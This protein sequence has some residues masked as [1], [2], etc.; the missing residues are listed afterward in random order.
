MKNSCIAYPERDALVIIRKSQVEFCDGNICA[1]ALLSFFEYWHNIKLEISV[2]NMAMNKITAMHGEEGYQDESLLQFHNMT[3]L[4]DGIMGLYGISTIKTARK[5]LV[6]KEIITEHRNPSE[7]YQFDHTI[8]YLFH[9]EIFCNWLNNRIVKNN[10]SIPPKL[11]NRK[12]ENNDS[13]VKNNDSSVKNNDSSVKNNGTITETS[14]KTS[15]K[16]TSENKDVAIAQKNSKQK[17]DEFYLAYPRKVSKEKAIKAW[18]KIKPEMYDVIIADVIN[19]NS[20]QAW[21]DK[22]F[23]IYPATYLNGKNWTDEIAPSRNNDQTDENTGYQPS[24]AMQILDPEY[25]ANFNA[26]HNAINS[27]S[28]RIQ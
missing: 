25:C 26:D 28:R 3:E 10:D 14:F 9:P 21:P 1:A 17:F 8:Y 24:M 19:R 2:K 27:E 5:L 23:I 20:R 7:R 16:T 6:N 15:F 11:T 22:S 4:S 13:S 18:N 12:T